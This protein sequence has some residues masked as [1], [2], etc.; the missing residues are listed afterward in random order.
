MC[1]TT[2]KS[3]SLMIDDNIV[4]E[5]INWWSPAAVFAKPPLKNAQKVFSILSLPLLVSFTAKIDETHALLSISQ[6]EQFCSK[7]VHW[8]TIYHKHFVTLFTQKCPSCCSFIVLLRMLN[9]SHRKKMQTKPKLRR[10]PH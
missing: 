7:D 10:N 9:Y 2:G 6:S 8:K 5:S 1:V 4:P 3:H